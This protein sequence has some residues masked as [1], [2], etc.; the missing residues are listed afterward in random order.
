MPKDAFYVEMESIAGFTRLGTVV[1][2]IEYLTQMII[3]QNSKTPQDG[4][5]GELI[6]RICLN[7]A[8]SYLMGQVP[9]GPIQDLSERQ[10]TGSHQDLHL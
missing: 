4:V 6:S 2:L 10:E 7:Q 3:S 5:Q 1:T 9:E 8:N